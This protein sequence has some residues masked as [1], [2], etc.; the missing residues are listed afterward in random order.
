[1]THGVFQVP[2]PKNEPVTD[3]A[4]NSPER[5]SLQA[6]LKEAAS[7]QVEVPLVIG[8]VPEIF[9][10]APVLLGPI[11]PYLSDEGLLL[12][13]FERFHFLG[14]VKEVHSCC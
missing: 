8:G 12:D 9:G 6:A 2:E 13:H 5:A 4:P 7:E 10:S 3:F 11:V 1:M 14:A